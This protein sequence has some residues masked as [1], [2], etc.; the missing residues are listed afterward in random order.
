MSVRR[1][2]LTI[3]EKGPNIYDEAAQPGTLGDHLRGRQFSVQKGDDVHQLVAAD[4]NQLKKGLKGRHMQMIAMYD[5]T[6]RHP[7]LYF[8]D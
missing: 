3:A 2:S 4:Q 8:I 6:H 7:L 1:E 5:F